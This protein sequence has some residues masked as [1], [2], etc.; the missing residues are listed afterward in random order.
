MMRY[1]SP[2]FRRSTPSLTDGAVQNC[3]SAIFADCLSFLWSHSFVRITYQEK[4]DMTARTMST[5][6]ESQS[7]LLMSA[8]TPYG[9]ATGAAAFSMISSKQK[10]PPLGGRLGKQCYWSWNF[11]L[12][13][14]QALIGLPS[15]VAGLYL[16]EPA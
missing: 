14:V 7:P 4:S 3:R 11:T 15:S 5:K 16:P 6:C 10:C 13:V 9:L 8:V 12:K 2:F 1:S